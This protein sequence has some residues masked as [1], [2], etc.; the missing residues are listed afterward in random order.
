VAGDDEAAEDVRRLASEFV[1]SGLSPLS[2]PL[3]S[4]TR[5]SLWSDP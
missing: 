2:A 1:Q 3:A 4:D 5:P